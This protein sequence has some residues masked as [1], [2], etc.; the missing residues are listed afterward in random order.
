MNIILCTLILWMPALV[1]FPVTRLMQAY[2]SSNHS[3]PYGDHLLIF[4]SIF[5]SNQI[6][7]SQLNNYKKQYPV[8]QY[9]KQRI[10]VPVTLP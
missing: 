3:Q 2:V 8:I 7:I 1:L 5:R 10:G 4:R 6:E 9:M